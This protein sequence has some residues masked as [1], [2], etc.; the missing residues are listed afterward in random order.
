MHVVTG[1]SQ[2]AGAAAIHQLRLVAATQ[3]MADQ[4]VPI[5]EADGVGALQPGHASN[6]IRIRCLQ[7]RVVVVAHQAKGMY[8]PTGFLTRLGQ[9]F[10][11]VVPVH[12][13]QEDVV[14]LEIVVRFL[15]ERVTV[16][17]GAG[18]PAMVAEIWRRQI[19]DEPGFEAVYVA[20]LRSV[21][22]PARLGARGSAEMRVGAEW[23]AAPRPVVVICK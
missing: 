4:P 9:S 8:L 13:P 15:R 2:I 6:Q 20:A 19:T 1:R 21:G 7:D 11:E 17:E 22:V 16:A 5:V 12:I 10:D 3:D 18:F 23:R 14:A